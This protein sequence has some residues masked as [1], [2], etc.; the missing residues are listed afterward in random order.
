MSKIISDNY[1]IWF[2]PFTVRYDTEFKGWPVKG[3]TA[4]PSHQSEGWP[5]KEH[6]SGQYPNVLSVLGL[7]EPC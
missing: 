3:L 5:E 2:P 4:T 7:L 1:V 6:T